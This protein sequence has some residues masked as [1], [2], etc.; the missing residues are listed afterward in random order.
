MESGQDSEPNSTDTDFDPESGAGA[1]PPS[2]PRDVLKRLFRSG[3]TNALLSWA[4]IAVLVSVFAEALLT[5]D[6]L[7]AIFVAVTGAIVVVPPVAYREWHVMLPWELLVIAL[8][9]ILVRGLFGG[10][11]GTFATYVAIAGVALLVTV[12]LHMFT[13]L[14]VTHWF[15]VVSVVMTTMAAAAAWAAVRWTMDQLFGTAF[16]TTNE[17]LMHEYISVTLAGL[18]AGV[19]F[20]AY[21]RRRDR[22]LHR[23]IVQVV[24]R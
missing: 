5:G 21:F 10:E 2:R 3:T 12:E 18:A 11:L 19:L 7:W 22:R 20:D 1:D 8:L 24:R 23:Q 14:E 9:P 6:R 17:A 16:L 15:A 4:L 13:A